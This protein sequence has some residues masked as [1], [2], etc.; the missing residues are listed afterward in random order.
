M[1]K[2][3]PKASPRRPSHTVKIGA[4]EAAVWENEGKNGTFYATTLKR[5]FRDGEEWK[6]SNSYGERDL[7]N[8]ARAALDCQ[9]FIAE[10]M[11]E[12][13]KKNAA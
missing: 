1:A 11:R 6:E 3:Q 10:K 8:L 12:A 4:I 13:A 2:Q 5:T 9:A 7:L